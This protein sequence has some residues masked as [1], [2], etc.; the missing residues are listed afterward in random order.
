MDGRTT[1]NNPE[2][3]R[4]FEWPPPES[5]SIA[6]GDRDVS[7]AAMEF[8]VGD[9]TYS[10]HAAASPRQ[11]AAAPDNRGSTGTT[12]WRKAGLRVAAICTIGVIALLS[13]GSAMSRREKK[14][15]SGTA[16]AA[17]DATLPSARIA[18]PAAE[19]RRPVG[20]SL[21]VPGPAGARVWLDGVSRGAAPLSI[22]DLTP[23]AHE[24][25]VVTNSAVASERVSIAAGSIATFVVSWPAQRWPARTVAPS[26]PPP[27]QPLVSPG[28]VAVALPFDVQI[29]ENGRFAGT[30]SAEVMLPPGPHRLELVNRSLNYSAVES[31]QVESDKAVKIP[32][33]APMSSVSLN[34]LPWAEVFIDGRR[35]GETPLGQV[36]IAVG[37][38]EVVFRHPQLGEQS[39]SITVAAGGPTR[40]SV[41]LRK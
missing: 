33:A 28:R 21:T 7:R 36:P 40:L 41:D 34:A 6:G 23:G 16:P 19:T 8:M 17:V 12:R 11:P 9:A 14:A 3:G 13:Q 1:H 32:A 31:V 38:H 25:R 24:V 10:S 20:G 5:V 4:Q 39:R 2:P 15:A 37:A 30:N 27:A 18:E 22:T 26:K 29:F 35:L